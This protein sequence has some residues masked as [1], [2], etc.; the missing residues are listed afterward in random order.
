MCYPRSDDHGFRTSV[1]TKSHKS[2]GN[3]N[4]SNSLLFTAWNSSCLSS[5]FF[6]V[7]R[8][9]FPQ[10][11][12]QVS[13][14]ASCRRSYFSHAYTQLITLLISYC[15]RRDSLFVRTRN[16]R[17]IPIR[18]ITDRCEIWRTPFSVNSFVPNFTVIGA[19]SCPTWRTGY[20]TI[21]RNFRGSHTS[22]LSPIRAKFGVSL[23]CA[24]ALQISASLVNN[25]APEKNHSSK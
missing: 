2:Y 20:L 16:Y 1:E 6:T 13:S 25:V 8:I 7:C 4:N 3:N 11:V 23:C 17:R 19:P 24:R 14:H 12:D 21:F 9:F 18:S 15:F 22:P 5:N 10:N